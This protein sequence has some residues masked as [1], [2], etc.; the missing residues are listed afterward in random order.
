MLSEKNICINVCIL[1]IVK[2]KDPH[3]V[4][5]QRAKAKGSPQL[6]K[7]VQDVIRCIISRW[8]VALGA[9]DRINITFIL[10]DTRLC[11]LDVKITNN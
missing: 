6:M 3:E 9:P 4:K 2:I 7:Y 5:N 1:I 11:Q 10:H 8:K